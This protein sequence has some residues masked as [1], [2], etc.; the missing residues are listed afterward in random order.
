MTHV[1]RRARRAPTPASAQTPRR[2]AHIGCRGDEARD[3][4]RAGS[5]RAARRRGR[6][7]AR[8][9]VRRRRRRRRRARGA[10]PCA[11]AR[12]RGRSRGR[13]CSRRSRAP[14]RST[15]SASTTPK[16]VEETGAQPPEAPIVFVKVAGS[17]APPGGPVRC[18]EVV[19][20][21]DYEGELTI[22]IGAG[23]R[24]R[25]LLRRRR[26]HRARPPGARAAVDAGQGRR[27]VLPVRAVG[28]HRRRGAR[29]GRPAAAD[30]GQRRAAPGQQHVGPDL[31]LRGA[32]RVHR[33]D[34]HAARPAT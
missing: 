9:R 16:H 12:S 27:H 7:R 4:P 20:R 2:H 13:R 15:R 21:L 11:P 3:L 30:L 31:R 6:R 1:R 32:R 28:H 29:P 8:R 33:R 23:R 34:V 14:G 25:R 19:R 26:R 10:Q 22:V 24:D 5:R 17:V 18:P